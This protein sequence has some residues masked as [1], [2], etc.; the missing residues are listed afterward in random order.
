MPGTEGGTEWA[1]ICMNYTGHNFRGFQQLF[2]TN[3]RAHATGQEDW[4]PK[5][6]S[7]ASITWAF[8][9][10]KHM[11]TW[12]G[13]EGRALYESLQTWVIEILFKDYLKRLHNSHSTTGFI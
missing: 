11:P 5:V 8:K 12:H 13:G 2:D 3:K 10:T 6:D 4:T 9:S 1:L 7:L